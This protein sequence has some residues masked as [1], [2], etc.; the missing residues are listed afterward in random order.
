[1]RGVSGVCLP[2]PAC[3]GLLCTPMAASWGHSDIFSWAPFYGDDDRA[4]RG[5]A[6]GGDTCG[7]T[8]PVSSRRS[9]PQETAVLLLP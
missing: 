3:C 6:V 8:V 2:G 5:P 1:M 9:H 4:G 7:Q